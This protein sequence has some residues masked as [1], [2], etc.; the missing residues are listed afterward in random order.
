MNIRAAEKLSVL[1]VLVMLFLF[2]VVCLSSILYCIIC[3]YRCVPIPQNQDDE[4][5]KWK[6]KKCSTKITFWNLIREKLAISRFRSA[7]NSNGENLSLKTGSSSSQM[8]SASMQTSHSGYES[9][10]RLTDIRQVSDHRS[11]SIQSIDDNNNDSV[12]SL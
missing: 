5:K 8:T 11:D 3:I 4:M 12:D 1:S 2:V 7:A 10:A 6:V 9:K